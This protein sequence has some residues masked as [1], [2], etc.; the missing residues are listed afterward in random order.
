[1]HLT[2]NVIVAVLI[3]ALSPLQAY[4]F[5]LPYASLT[6]AEEK[7]L[8]DEFM[9]H[10]KKRCEFIEDPCIVDYVNKIGQEIVR[11]HPSPPF[12]FKFYIVK[13]DVYNA[14]AIGLAVGKR[15]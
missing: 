12:S 13:E 15:F 11:Q 6:T 3:I 10:L 1:M 4:P 5:L 9:R 14:V 8:G 7:E 2:R